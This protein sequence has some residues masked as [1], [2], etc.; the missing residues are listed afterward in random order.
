MENNQQIKKTTVPASHPPV[1]NSIMIKSS[2]NLY[3]NKSLIIPYL[4]DT[5][6]DMYN[7]IYNGKEE[8]LEDIEIEAK[9][10]TFIFK[11]VSVLGY[12]Y[13][14][15]TFKIPIWDVKDNSN[16]YDFVSGLDEDKFYLIWHFVDKEAENPHSGIKKLPAKNYK[17]VHYKSGKR[18]SELIE[19][20]RVVAEETIKKEDKLHS[21]IRNN[22]LDFRITACIERKT[23][24]FESDEET[25]KRDKF[26]VSYEYNFFRLDFTIVNSCNNYSKSELTYEIEFEFLE[27]EIKKQNDYFKE[28]HNFEY[29]FKRYFQNVFCIY[30]LCTPDYYSDKLLERGNKFFGNLYGN[31]LEKNFDKNKLNVEEN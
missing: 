29:M 18:K 13:I 25:L 15:E 20:N 23:D 24:I 17:E 2:F 30:E 11:G 26:R 9:L 14:K 28:F 10:G 3:F 7:F 4:N 6:H 8:L 27:K 16:K 12:Q 19:N 5:I 22:G 21:N 31:Y 1:P